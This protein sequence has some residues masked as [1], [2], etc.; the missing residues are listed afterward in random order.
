MRG[1]GG[2]SD[3]FLESLLRWSQSISTQITQTIIPLFVD[4][5]VL[6][7]GRFFVWWCWRRFGS[8]EPPFESTTPIQRISGRSP[9]GDDLLLKEVPSS[10]GCLL[11]ILGRVLITGDKRRG[12][13]GRRRTT[14]TRPNHTRR[15]HGDRQREGVRIG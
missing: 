13:G 10:T 1:R 12:G 7:F 9:P 8:K 15:F 11:S 2:F 14:T 5:L 4:G 3:R 6:Q